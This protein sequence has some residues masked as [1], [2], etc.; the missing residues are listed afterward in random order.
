VPEGGNDYWVDDRSNVGDQ[1]TPSAVGDNRNTGKL[2]TAPKP[3]P[4]NLLRT[5]A[6]GEGARLFVDTGGYSLIDPVTVSGSVDLG[7]G[8]DE[9]FLMTGPTNTAVVAELFPA[10]PDDRS[11]ALVELDDAD[12]VEVAFLTLRDAERGLHVH[13]GSEDFSARNITAFGHA[14]DGIR[15]DSS[16]PGAD[17]LQL[18]SHDNGGFGIAIDGPFDTLVQSLAYE[19]GQGGFQIAGPVARVT[20]NVARDNAGSGFEIRGAPGAVVQGNASFGNQRGMVVSN[21]GSDTVLRTL[22]GATTL[23]AGTANLVYGNRVDGIVARGNVLVAGNSVADQTAAAATGITI[24]DGAS[25]QSNLVFGNGV[26]I[27]VSEGLVL[28]NRVY[29]N[30]SIGIAADGATIAENVVYSSPVGVAVTGNGT[31]L[32]N[33]L[34]YANTQVGIEV[35]AATKTTLV[36]NTVFELAGDAVRLQDRSADTTL[37][38]NILWAENGF[39]LAVAADS[40]TGFASDFNVFFRSLF[41]SGSLGLWDGVARGS[42]AQWQA[43]SGTDRNSLFANPLFV[44]PNGADNVLGAGP[45][46]DGRDDDFHLQSLFGSFHGGALAPVEGPSFGSAPGR[47]VPLTP[48]EMRD[49]AQ[50]PAI[51]RGSPSDPFSREPIFNGGRIDVGAY[52]NTP[53]ASKSPPPIIGVEPSAGTFASGEFADPGEGVLIDWDRWLTPNESAATAF[54]GDW[55]SLF[56]ESAGSSAPGRATAAMSIQL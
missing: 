22:V 19:N 41:G 11:R 10:I 35:G 55:K 30:R 13:D 42:L 2:P 50:S 32:S 26:G 52:G 20:G 43:A 9:G 24:S 4:T 51:D 31:T 39:A 7:L 1:Y 3:Y 15:I 37:R 21:P 5:Y 28:G 25:A 8:R 14:L 29:L 6:L 17:F 49:N 34:V 56:A 45:T 44:D 12:S 23:T 46:S 40:E 16:A 33:N 18:T 47:P 38:N 27:S 48:V 54:P 36:N 53:Q